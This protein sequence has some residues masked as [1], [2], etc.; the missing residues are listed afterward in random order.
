VEG[1][2]D[3][4]LKDSAGIARRGAALAYPAH[5]CRPRAGRERRRVGNAGAARI[6]GVSEEEEESMTTRIGKSSYLGSNLEWSSAHRSRAAVGALGWLATALMATAAWQAS[7]ATAQE[8]SDPP[9]RF[10]VPGTLELSR[11]SGAVE[12]QSFVEFAAPRA[13]GEAIQQHRGPVPCAERPAGHGDEGAPAVKFK[14]PKFD[15]SSFKLSAYCTVHWKAKKQNVYFKLEYDVE[16]T[17]A[18]G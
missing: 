17:G 14:V 9:V 3:D 2:A 10:E 15:A 12:K 6:T 1:G 5:R 8:S 13:V 11:A 18:T 16:P 4:S 7:P